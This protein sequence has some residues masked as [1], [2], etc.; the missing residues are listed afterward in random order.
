MFSINRKAENL[1]FGNK[2]ISNLFGIKELGPLMVLVVL[3]L[4]FYFMNNTFLSALNLSNM[5]FYIPELGIIAIGMTL[6]MIAGEI[7]LSV[8]AL[9]GGIPVIMYVLYNELTIPFWL[10]FLIALIIT[11]ILGF[12]N[13]FIVTQ[14]DMSSIIVT[15]AMML[16]VRGSALYITN[17]FPQTTYDTQS[18]VKQFLI[19]TIFKKGDFSIIYSLIWFI[20]LIFLLHFI[21]NNTVFGNWI[22][23]TGGN[24][25]AARARGINTNRVRI[26][27]FMIS[28]FLAGF[29]GIISALRVKSAYPIAGEG[30]ELE[31]IAMIVIGGTLLSGGKGTIIGT[32]IGVLILRTIRNGIIMIGVPGLA[33]KIFVGT[34]IIVMMIFH[35]FITKKSR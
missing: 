28:S 24:P 19:G 9:F 31:V 14:F 34:I 7:D 35:A 13:G 29:A 32:V 1:K 11:A 4:I 8:G 27:L 6:L 23:A 20:V 33:Y 10:A 5:F 18:W 17:G 22:M 30:Y 2:N 12:I 3:V 26:I 15:I 21:L 25:K 16:V